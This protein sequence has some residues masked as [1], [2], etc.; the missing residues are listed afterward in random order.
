[1]SDAEAQ[2]L[3]GQFLQSFALLEQAL[4][5]GIGKILDLDKDKTEIVCANIPFARKAGVFFSAEHRTASMPDQSR[6]KLLKDTRGSV[7]ALN[8]WRVIFAHH[9]FTSDGQD[10]VRLRR[11]VANTKLEIR[12]IQLSPGDVDKLCDKA[13]GAAGDIDRIVAE[14]KSYA[15][16]LDFSDPRNSGYIA[17][18]F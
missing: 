4:N 1:M 9:P 7:L 6:A 18:L 2:R 11:V 8:D 16:S 17:L 10:G 14:M 12:D 13:K 5:A 15:P 3:V